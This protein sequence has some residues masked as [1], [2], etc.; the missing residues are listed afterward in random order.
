MFSFGCERDQTRRKVTTSL[1]GPFSIPEEPDQRSQF[2]A[3]YRERIGVTPD[4]TIIGYE[5]HPF[6]LRRDEKAFADAMAALVHSVVNEPKRGMLS[7][8]EEWY[9]STHQ[10]K[11]LLLRRQIISLD[12][13]EFEDEIWVSESIL[14][15]MPSTNVVR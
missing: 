13:K 10:I 5:F 11:P 1:F 7:V 12:R 2:L 14:K 8:T 3:A 4:S 15:R 9:Y 6:L